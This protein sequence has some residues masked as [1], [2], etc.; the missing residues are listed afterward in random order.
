MALITWVEDDTGVQE[1]LRKLFEHWHIPAQGAAD[2]EGAWRLFHERPTPI[3]LVDLILPGRGG[4]WFIEQIRLEWP[5]TTCL[6]M[7]GSADKETLL[8]CMRLGVLRYFT[9]PL[10]IED[11]HG[12]LEQQIQLVRE[13]RASV[14]HV[15]D[16]QQRLRQSAR[17]QA[18][19]IAQASESL[20]VALSL[21]DPIT[22]AHCRRVCQYARAFGRF[23]RLPAAHL[24]ALDLAAR[25]HDLG[26][27]GIPSPLLYHPGPLEETE[28]SLV[29]Q[30]PVWS[31]QIVRPLVRH[32]LVLQAI[33]HHHERWDGKGYPDG[34]AEGRIPLLARILALLD[35]YDAITS[36]RPYRSPRDWAA[37]CAELE[38][39]AGTQ[40]DPQ[41]TQ[42]FVRLVRRRS[43]WFV[44]EPPSPRKA[45]LPT[46]AETSLIKHNDTSA[47]S[48]SISARE[49]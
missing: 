27:M 26:K 33:R 12:V 45:A 30:H 38:S 25:F 10:D 32:S 23:L 5:E 44:P 34:L 2:A 7:S 16:L 41:L 35:A 31:E 39:H 46:W 28:W 47:A 3:V 42:T 49:G 43:E 48:E 9:K 4:F 40:F 29:R 21:H 13:R 37:A 24:V 20:L 11:L 36:V 14:R 15:H 17:R 18:E 19:K 8:R 1:L 22:A 6:V